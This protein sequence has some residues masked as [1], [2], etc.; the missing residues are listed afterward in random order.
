MKAVRTDVKILV[1]ADWNE[2]RTDGAPTEGTWFPRLLA[3][4]TALYQG[5]LVDAY[6]V[7]LYCEG[8]SPADTTTKQLWRY[9]RVFLSRNAAAAKGA[10]KPFWT[11]ELGWSTNGDVDE[12]TQA[13]YMR[14]AL[15]IAVE[16][17]GPSVVERSF[18]YTLERPHNSDRVGA[19]NMIR[20]DG[21][22]KPAWAAVSDLI[23][24]GS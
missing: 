13:S 24:N 12:A 2:G 8:R 19:Y 1:A 22:F 14:S 11:T 15:K 21:S 7:H 18:I 17:W 10:V 4:D 5:A 23:L 3:N 6:T 16:S 20:D 9:D